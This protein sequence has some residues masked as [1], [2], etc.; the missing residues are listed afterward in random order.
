MS[1]DKLMLM[2]ATM[3]AD[4]IKSFCRKVILNNHKKTAAGESP[5]PICIWGTH[6]IGKTAVVEA[7]AKENDWKFAY[8]A[9]AQFE[10]MGDLHG[11]PKIEN[12][13]TIFAIPDWVPTEDGP[14]IL[15]LDDFNRADDRILRGLMQLLQRSE[16]MSWSLPKDWQI[17]VTAN[18]E[19]GNYSVTPMDDAMLTRM[20][21][22]SMKFEAK[23]WA[24][25]A[26]NNKV[27]ERGINFVL[28]YPEIVSGARTTPRSLTHFFEQISSI[29][30]LMAEWDMVHALALSALDE[31]TA[32]SFM[33]FVSDNLTVLVSPE[34]IL[35]APKWPPVNKRIKDLATDENGL[36]LD[37]INTVCDRLFLA[38]TN[39]D[40]CPEPSHEKNL[41]A[42]MTHEAI[43]NDLRVILHRDLIREGS[44]EVVNMMRHKKLALLALE[45]I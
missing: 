13:N 34:E 22:V 30:D 39:K 45:A 3:A 35:D 9:P 1:N 40:Y 23:A 7:I 25:W 38:L 18:P 28:M 20:L 29:D 44:H 11:L 24:R 33:S 27:D 4:G 43:P 14:G 42:F 2:G 15:L 32:T 19:G 37:R 8:I 21:H 17:V 10:E 31:E 6:G 5:V 12:D 41:I 16:L 26:S 36:R